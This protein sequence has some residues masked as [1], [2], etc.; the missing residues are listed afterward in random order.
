M[1]IRLNP[2]ACQS[3][4]LAVCL[5]MPMPLIASLANHANALPQAEAAATSPAT[6]A[7]ADTAPAAVL[8]SVIFD[9]R[10]MT[11]GSIVGW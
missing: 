5:G 1:R 6:S 3:I 8:G 4:V 7:A 9:S 10:V 11:T 2:V